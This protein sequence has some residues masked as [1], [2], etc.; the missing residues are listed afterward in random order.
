[1]DCT[2][3]PKPGQVWPIRIAA[4][5][6]GPGRPHSELML[7]PDHAVYVEDV[8]I[9]IKFLI[10]GSTI[11]QMPVDHVTYYHI[12]LSQHDVVLAQGL[13]AES[14]LD[15]RDGSNYANRSGPVRLYPNFSAGMWEAFGC[16]RLIVT[17]PELTAAR[18]SVQ[19]CAT[20][21]GP[22]QR[23]PIAFEPGTVDAVADVAPLAHRAVA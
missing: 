8:L 6:F 19:R 4:R 2:R 15:M 20:T 9:P 1:V 3:H 11:A 13:P 23:Q 10:N 5:A 22:E 18:E 14:F 12:E 7:S 17:G 16:A 21:V